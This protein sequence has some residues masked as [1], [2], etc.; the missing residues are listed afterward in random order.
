M[1]G[2]PSPSD[3]P[4]VPSG[5][6]VAVARAADD[7]D[8]Q[9]PPGPVPEPGPEP[10][11]EPGLEAAPWGASLPWW[12]VDQGGGT[13][14]QNVQDGT[15]PHAVPPP[16]NGTGPLPVAPQP[17]LPGAGPGER[18]PVPRVLLGAGVG[19]LLV[20]VLLAGVLAFRSNGGKKTGSEITASKRRITAV[21]VAGGL[22]RDGTAQPVTSAAYP[23]VAAAVKA[24]GVPVSKDGVAVYADAPGGPLNV[25]FMGGTGAVGDPVAF[26]R[27]I[28]PPTFIAAQS[29]GP[30]KEGGRALCGSFAV[31]AEV[32]VYCAWAT[33]DSY[34]VVA[35]NIAVRAAAN[36]TNATNTADAVGSPGTALDVTAAANQEIPVVA[37]LMRR[38]RQDVE[39]PRR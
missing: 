22:R 14:P 28:R 27:T 17:P 33:K 35:S 21:A 19:A 29:T 12:S 31:L 39:K 32:H 6:D 13:G 37:D 11:L 30:G 8:P 15:G 18:G 20:V 36:A 9:P 25:L 38:I 23:F 16:P 34:G 7:A 10:G 3:A 26:L 24:G 5:D 1:A 4:D 2:S